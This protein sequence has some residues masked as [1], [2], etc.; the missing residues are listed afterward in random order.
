MSIPKEVVQLHQRIRTLL[1]TE[2]L[3]PEVWEPLIRDFPNHSLLFLLIREVLQRYPDSREALGQGKETSVYFQDK[4]IL[5]LLAGN[6]TRIEAINFLQGICHSLPYFVQLVRFLEESYQNLR[7]F[8]ANANHGH[9]EESDLSRSLYEHYAG[10]PPIKAESGSRPQQTPAPAKKVHHFFHRWSPAVYRYFAAAA[11]VLLALVYL[12]HQRTSRHPGDQGL[13]FDT[14][15]PFEY[16]SRTYRGSSTKP[17][18][19]SPEV[20]GF[21]DQVLLGIGSYSLRHYREAIDL[22]QGLESMAVSLQS[23]A[24]PAQ[25]QPWLFRYYF[26]W[27]LSHL[28]YSRT[29]RERLSSEQRSRHLQAAITKLEKARQLVPPQPV[30]E[31][32]ALPYF[33]GLTYFLDHQQQVAKKYLQ[34]VNPQSPF[35][36]QAAQL[37]SRLSAAH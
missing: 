23:S 35:G 36:A 32:T 34:Q 25:L 30:R 4:E 19:L 37:L 2:S 10:F 13:V 18:K 17:G 26:Y 7:Q 5:S 6:Y 9:G 22:F 15:V 29:R 1:L 28:A 20:R 27:G 11:V 33:L 3:T 14:Q 8:G 16:L 12:L 31:L 24:E 21:V